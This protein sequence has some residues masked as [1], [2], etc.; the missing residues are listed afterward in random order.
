MHYVRKCCPSVWK[1]AH[2][3]RYHV[4]AL[5]A[6]LSALAALPV[7]AETSCMVDSAESAAARSIVVEL[8]S[9]EVP[10]GK[11]VTLR[12]RRIAPMPEHT[13][14]LLVVSAPEIAR[15]AGR[16]S[17]VKSQ[18]GIEDYLG[19]GFIALAPSAPAPYGIG[20][21]K[22]RSRILV[23]LQ[24]GGAGMAEVDMASWRAGTYELQWA[25]FKADTRCAPLQIAAGRLPPLV[26]GPGAPTV[27]V[28]DYF[29][30]EDELR[31]AELDP[32]KRPSAVVLAR[33]G[34]YRLH[35]YDGRYRVFDTTGTKIVDRAGWNARFSPTS[36]F[37]VAT[38][39]DPTQVIPSLEVVDLA[40][41]EVVRQ[42]TG[43]VVGWSYADSFLITG[44]LHYSGVNLAP[45]LV[46]TVVFG[47]GDDRTVVGD[48][49]LGFG[50]NTCT[51]WESTQ[52]HIMLDQGLVAAQGPTGAKIVELATSNVHQ[53]DDAFT[54]ADAAKGLEQTFRQLTGVSGFKLGKGWQSD[55][56]IALT[57]TGPSCQRDM[58]ECTNPIRQASIL[59]AHEQLKNLDVRT[60]GARQA[61]L[62]ARPRALWSRRSFQPDAGGLGFRTRLNEL[63]DPYGTGFTGATSVTSVMPPPSKPGFSGFSRAYSDSLRRSIVAMAPKFAEIY[64]PCASAESD[65]CDSIVYGAWDLSSTGIKGWVVQHANFNPT[66][67]GAQDAGIYVLLNG[68]ARLLKEIDGIVSQFWTTD[69]YP[70][71]VWVSEGRF[72]IIAHRGLAQAAIIDTIS[73]KRFALPRIEQPELLVSLSLSIDHRLVL[74]HNAD[75]QFFIY[76]RETGEHLLSGRYVD[77]E[78][79]VWDRQGIY[80]S[81]YEGA[82]F[83]YLRFAGTDGSATFH[84]Y[85]ARLHKPDRINAILTTAHASTEPIDPIAAP[86]R[87]EIGPAT[88]RGD[89][90][91]VVTA[92]SDR[93]LAKLRVFLDGNA[94]EERDI[95]GTETRETV[96]LDHP[97][98]RRWLTAIALDRDGF[99]SQPASISLS[100]SGNATG[101][102]LGVLVAVDTYDDP[103]ISKLNYARS[104]ASKMARALAANP[105]HYYADIR[106]TTLADHDATPTAVLDAIA[107]AVATGGPQDTLIVF[108]AGHGTQD[109][110]GYYLTASTTERNRITQTALPW[111]RVAEVLDKAQARVIVVLDACHAGRS[112][113]DLL[114]SNDD[115][116]RGLLASARR[117]LVVLSAAKGRQESLEDAKFGGGLFTDAVAHV[118]SGDRARFDSNGNGVIELSELY[119]GVKSLVM[120]ASRGT[121]TPWLARQ[122][123]I[124]DVALF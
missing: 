119:A 66:T 88:G 45:V 49:A 6:V 20:F 117:P 53:I 64:K 1:L 27:T 101:R 48:I 11:S 18:Y 55:S 60:A 102:L 33:S 37:V 86:P 103:T 83:V 72:L 118:I 12:W 104:D 90:G 65:D 51:G 109:A 22:D 123:F 70:A 5:L 112:G 4:F 34:R 94:I 2:S 79:V 39:G 124:G 68:E 67:T 21:A 9:F 122:D 41:G 31:A 35:S 46:D 56:G 14:L 71:Q 44:Q 24:V 54:A 62:G 47:S 7:M 93:G 121:Q 98:R 19:P 76:A 42:A 59:V 57:H 113:A 87:V 58:E 120:S 82:H 23:P 40:S 77:D 75:D 97:G 15:F 73:A 16:W 81:S 52:F 26:V 114:G 29:T 43:P 84:Q 110:S 74:Q 36:R 38:I 25:V 99:V 85:A 111:Q 89:A 105:A 28:Q 30:L 69:R 92:R 17:S 63:L 50:C 96:L 13:R 107:H 10:A 3:C 32:T 91:Y 100:P 115:A 108:Y 61:A 106:L 116:V 8:S 78:I 95:S 80:Q